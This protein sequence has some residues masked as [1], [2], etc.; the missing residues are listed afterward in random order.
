MGK[1]PHGRCFFFLGGKLLRDIKTRERHNGAELPKTLRHAPKELAQ[2]GLRAAKE[3][4]KEQLQQAAQNGMGGVEQVSPE[5]T[6]GD[7]LLGRAEEWGGTVTAGGRDMLR[8]IPARANA[9]RQANRLEK[10]RGECT[11]RSEHPAGALFQGKKHMQVPRTAGRG[12]CPQ[13]GQA[14]CKGRP[15]AGKDAAGNPRSQATGGAHGETGG[16][17]GKA[18]G[19]SCT[20]SGKVGGQGDSQYRKS[21]YR[22]S[23]KPCGCIGCGRRACTVYCS[24]HLFDCAGG[25]FRIR[26]LLFVRTDREGDDDEAGSA[27]VERRILP[28]AQRDRS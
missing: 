23:Q 16:T 9:D 13:D 3:K 2:K 17:A 20:T 26:Y 8:R 1:D 24:T 28:E 21:L 19:E 5:E 7:Q 11:W 4:G 12:T 25:G 6:A 15:P 18:G 10:Q 22:G 27:D 14:R